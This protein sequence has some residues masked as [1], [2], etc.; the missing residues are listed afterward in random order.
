MTM[1]RGWEMGME[2]GLTPKQKAAFWRAFSAAKL[3]VQPQDAD[4]WR[5]KILMEETGKMSLLDVNRRG[6]FEAVMRRLWSEAGNWDEA[7][8]YTVG[9]ERRAAFM[10]KVVATQ[11]LQLLGSDVP[12]PDAYL[13]GVLRQSRLVTTAV[14]ERG[15]FWMDIPLA[16]TL[17]VFQMLDTHRRRLLKATGHDGR[18]AFSPNVR[19][20]RDGNAILIVEHVAASYYA[21]SSRPFVQ[22]RRDGR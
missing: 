14:A 9:D 16:N 4:A 8:R 22:V 6:E 5:H 21:Q 13:A 17:K 11:V 15:D 2:K 10:I 20:T 3:V 1:Q 19:Y 18:A 7:V 12:G